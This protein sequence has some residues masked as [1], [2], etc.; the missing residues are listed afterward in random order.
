MS[1][2]KTA[3][4]SINEIDLRG[5]LSQAIRNVFNTMLSIKINP[6]D[7]EPLEA[8]SGECIVGIVGFAGKAVGAVYIHVS[9]SLAK[10]IA[11][12]I[13][14]KKIEDVSSTMVNDVVGEV[15][16]MVA[17]NLK[18]SLCD[19][20]FKCALTIPSVTR[21]SNFQIRTKYGTRQEQLTFAYEQH[22]IILEVDIKPGE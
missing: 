5:F 9:E 2:V 7:V 15:C 8:I 3:V 14:G 21:G 12:R 11:A 18:S 20:Q 4:E 13:L 1:S 16:N 17:G 19:H 6:S 22:R 10:I